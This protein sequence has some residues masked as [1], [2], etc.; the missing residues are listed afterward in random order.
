MPLRRRHRRHVDLDPAPPLRPRPLSRVLAGY[1]TLA[2][3]YSFSLYFAATVGV[4]MLLADFRKQRRGARS[5]GGGPAPPASPPPLLPDPESQRDA[6]VAAEP[7]IEGIEVSHEFIEVPVYPDEAEEHA[8]TAKT[9]TLHLARA[10]IDPSRRA[11]LF[12]HGF[13][14][15]W[16]SWR[17]LMKPL[18]EAGY[19][20]AALDMRGYNL[21][22]KPARRERGTKERLLQSFCPLRRGCSRP[23]TSAPWPPMPAPPRC[24]S[25][26]STGRTVTLVSH[27]WGGAVAWH[28]ASVD[29]SAARGGEGGGGGELLPRFDF[30]ESGTS[31]PRRRRRLFDALVTM[32]IPHPLLFKPTWMEAGQAVLVRGLL[33]VSLLPEKMMAGDEPRRS[34]L[35]AAAEERG[36]KEG[37][38]RDRRRVR[39]AWGGDGGDKLLPRL[40]AGHRRR[41]RCRARGRGRRGRCAAAWTCRCSASTPARDAALGVELLAGSERFCRA[42]VEIEILDSGHWIQLEKAQECAERTLRFLERTGGN[43]GRGSLCAKKKGKGKVPSRVLLCLFFSF[44]CKRERKS[45]QHCGGKSF[46]QK[47]RTTDKRLLFSLSLLSSFKGICSLFLFL[48]HLNPPC[49]SRRR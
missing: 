41:D 49:S 19:E 48:P 22:G 20:V 14:E 45:F 39:E 25:S 34:E 28:A 35:D 31:P 7:G 9:T 37:S 12:L 47:K 3:V 24:T 8:G 30:F 15:C 13:P 43:S 27:D 1:L 11:V 36:R 44:L 5:G 2:V 38:G 10:G 21:S 6:A 46:F 33:P 17:R 40:R 18:V 16:L 26:G 4:S 42:G 32:A 23:L 29:S